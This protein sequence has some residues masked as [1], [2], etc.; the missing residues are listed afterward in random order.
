MPSI[1]PDDSCGWRRLRA[2]PEPE[3]LVD[4]PAARAPAGQVRAED[5]GAADS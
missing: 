1:L 4:E 5:L 3:D 2:D